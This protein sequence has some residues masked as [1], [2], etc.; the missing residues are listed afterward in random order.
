MPQIT[1]S[2]TDETVEVPVGSSLLE[3]CE[4]HGAPVPFSC[5][6]GACGTCIIALEEGAGNV[7]EVAADERQTILM[8]TDV[9]G[10]RLACQLIVQGDITVKVLD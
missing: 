4:E 8:T 6:S 2:D 7:N 3:V 1:F 5:T 9:E 10:A